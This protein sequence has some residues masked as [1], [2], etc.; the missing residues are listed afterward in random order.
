MWTSSSGIFIL[1][2]INQK[3]LYFEINILKNKNITSIKITKDEFIQFYLI[4]SKIDHMGNDNILERK[5]DFIKR[6]TENQFSNFRFFLIT[7]ILI[8]IIKLKNK[9]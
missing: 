8:T 4:I 9:F 2:R 6:M 7:R 3:Y 5:H 1:R